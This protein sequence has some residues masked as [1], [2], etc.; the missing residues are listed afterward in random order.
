MTECDGLD[1][2]PGRALVDKCG[3]RAREEELPPPLGRRA[4][5]F[6]STLNVRNP[7]EACS[8]IFKQQRF[9]ER[10]ND[11]EQQWIDGLSRN[12]R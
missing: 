10:D 3:L 2:S 11:D 5:R 7:L 9:V 6:P 8:I 1:A 4:W 12:P